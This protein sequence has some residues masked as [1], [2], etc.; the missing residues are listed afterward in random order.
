MHPGSA[1][2]PAPKGSSSRFFLI[3][4]CPVRRSGFLSESR[5]Y[6]AQRS[7]GEMATSSAPGSSDPQQNTEA[8]HPALIVVRA[9]GLP[10]IETVFREERKYYVTATDGVNTERTSVVQS[11]GQSVEW[12]ETLRGFTVIPSS[13]LIVRVFARRTT[14]KDILLAPVALPFESLR[15]FSLQE[16]DLPVDPIQRTTLVLSLAL[17]EAP[18]R[19]TTSVI[20]SPEV[21]VVPGEAAAQS[22]ALPVSPAD[23]TQVAAE[24]LTE[25]E[26]AIANL[27]SAPGLPLRLAKA[28]DEAPGNL[29]GAIEV[30]DTWSIALDNV[31][32]VV[33][34]VDKIAEIHPWAKMAWSVLSC[35]PKTFIAQVERDESFMAL[36]VAIRDAFDL[37]ELATGLERLQPRSVQ[38]TIMKRML[39]HVCECGDLIQN[40]AK[41]A[42]F[43]KRF[44]Q[45]VGRGASEQV[46]SYSDTLTKLRD[47]FLRHGAI[48]TEMT[49]LKIPARIDALSS[50]LERVASGVADVGMIVKIGEIPYPEGT[51]FR[52]DKRCSPGTRVAFLDYVTDWVNNPESSRALVLFGESGTGK[53]SIANEIAYRFYQTQRLGSSFAFSRT[54]RSNRHDYLLFTGLVRDLADRYPSFRASLGRII[55]NDT[56][57][58]HGARD[59]ATIFESMLLQSLEGVPLIGPVLIVIDAL[60]ESG[61]ASGS[62][63]LHTF[64]ASRIPDLPPNFRVF[65]TSRSEEN[66]T[67]AFNKAAPPP[68]EIWHMEHPLLSSQAAGDIRSYMQHKLPSDLFE[69]YGAKL[70]EKS[71]QSFQWAA[72]ASDYI[73]GL[74]QT[75]LQSVD[76]LLELPQ[77]AQVT[78]GA[79]DSLYKTVLSSYFNDD[80]VLTLFRSVMGQLVAAIEPLSVRSLAEL[81]QYGEGSSGIL[82]EQPIRAIV[83]QLGSLLNNAASSDSSLPI[84]PLHTSFH[85]FLTDP[86]RAGKFCVDLEGAHCQLAY[87]SLGLMHHKLRFNICRL[88][89]SYNRNAAIPDLLSRIA[90]HISSAL[91]YA[92][93]CWDDHLRHVSSGVF[94]GKVLAFFENDF[95]F[96]LEALSLL[97]ATNLA[98]QAFSTVEVWHAKQRDP[99]SAGRARHAH[100]VDQ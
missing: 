15:P 72:V 64:L 83:S 34:V 38:A 100:D 20:S 27:K 89:S 56:S 73:Q 43:W 45:T 60:D 93:R 25:A 5:A 35:I 10:R 32:W 82:D 62:S 92:C 42:D 26:E 63:G 71:V 33:D 50:Q 28:A 91:S 76:N 97:G 36:L 53:S 12:G 95:P 90:R 8:V 14:G 86:K 66:V 68:A 22:G 21:S 58:R 39:Y 16:F 24:R 29:G 13:R 23:Q 59:Y 57:L 61:D 94:L 44:M 69:S 48:T 41:N 52:P 99:P 9:T 7:A 51:R 74:G 81:R 70:A 65:I 98:P 47:D 31:K 80:N 96:W 49:V 84:S 1:Q 88:P 85:D 79:L 78:T 17:P 87:C 4:L 2:R 46:K 40:Y 3:D 11:R 18:Q 75:S 37:A 54:E 55:D 30:Y 19:A 67:Y 77:D 6:I